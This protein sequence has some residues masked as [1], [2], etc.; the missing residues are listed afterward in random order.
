[1]RSRTA[2]SSSRS[3]TDTQA[4]GRS[5]RPAHCAS[6]VVLPEPAGAVIVT[7]GK[8][9]EARSR[10]TS[11]VRRTAFGTGA[12]GTTLAVREA[13]G[14]ATERR[15]SIAVAGA[16]KGVAMTFAPGGH[17]APA[18]VATRARTTML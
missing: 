9:R 15:V 16:G 10:L 8:V 14:S 4:T 18:P 12:G 3:S 1:W 6:A 2:G 13:N 7:S 5:S 11:A 17:H